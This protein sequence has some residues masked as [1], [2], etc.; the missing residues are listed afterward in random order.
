MD[1]CARRKDVTRRIVRKSPAQGPERLRGIAGPSDGPGIPFQVWVL[2]QRDPVPIH[3]TRDQKAAAIAGYQRGRATREQFYEAGITKSQIQT[4]TRSGAPHPRPPHALPPGVL[5]N[6]SPKLP[7]PNPREG[8]SGPSGR[9]PS[10][11]APER[12][13][14]EIDADLTL[15][16]LEP[17]LDDGLHRHIIR[18]THLGMRASGGEHGPGGDDGCGARGEAAAPQPGSAA[19]WPQTTVTTPAT[20]TRARPRSHARGDRG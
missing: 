18:L 19:A 6:S 15:T 8:R 2:G 16:P 5:V 17:A 13:I 10:G 7:K 1:R 20:P 4:M 11:R 14:A 9:A 3:G 12:S